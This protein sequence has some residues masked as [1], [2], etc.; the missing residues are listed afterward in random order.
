MLGERGSDEVA[1]AAG[2]GAGHHRR[3][4]RRASPREEKELLQD[5]AVLGKVFWLGAARA[6]PRA[7]GR[8]RSACTRSSARE[9]VRTRAA[10]VR[11]GRESSTPSGT[12][13]VRDVAYGQIPRGRAGGAS[14]GWPP[15][16][17]RRSAGREDHAEMLAHHYLRGAR[18]RPGGRS[19]ESPRSRRCPCAATPEAGDRAFVAQLVRRGC[20]F[21]RR[22]A[23]ARPAT[24]D[25]RDYCFGS[26]ARRRSSSPAAT[27]AEAALEA[28]RDGA[29]REPV[30]RERAAEAD[31]HLSR[32][33]V[34]S[35]PTAQRSLRA[36]STRAHCARR[37]ADRRRASK[38]Y[39]L[40]Q[41]GATSQHARAAHEEAMRTSARSA[42]PGRGLGLDELRA[43]RPR[44]ASAPRGSRSAI[45]PGS[46]TLE[47]AHRDRALAARL[48]R[49]RARA[50]TISRM[51]LGTLG[52]LSRARTLFERRRLARERL[53]DRERWPG[54]P[55]E[56]HVWLLFQERRLG[57]GSCCRR[58]V[59][60]RLRRRRVA[61]IRRAAAR[62]A[63]R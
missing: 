5:A 2:D 19:T 21:L 13:L 35:R 10:L 39:V 51:A 33:L 56:C 49:G 9:F 26:G 12:S 23:R 42:R 4:P 43:P 1:A 53:G 60:G 22:G 54:S 29:A 45:P 15:S 59:P 11:G 7:A 40:S 31:T 34:A 47:Q 18:A 61:A 17:S 27:D 57:R 30:T 38:A 37:R 20:A 58:R 41:P 55:R 50:T 3:A 6:R 46:T 63:A 32:A 24:T 52:D 25:E 48:T 36:T 44:H 14:T 8:S 28:A 62:C 16:G